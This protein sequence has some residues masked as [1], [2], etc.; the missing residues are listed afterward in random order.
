MDWAS[1][2]SATPSTMH[3]S[4][5]TH[6]DPEA[7]VRNLGLGKRGLPPC[8]VSQFKHHRVKGI[9]DERCRNGERGLKERARL[10]QMM[11]IGGSNRGSALFGRY[12][13]RLSLEIG[14]GLFLTSCRIAY[15]MI[16]HAR[17]RDRDSH[18]RD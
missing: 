15:C 7:E 12:W 16:S 14:G 11:A 10:A 13:A 4:R 3:K 9:E 18:H 2:N 1:T 5:S 8:A 17:M 6:P